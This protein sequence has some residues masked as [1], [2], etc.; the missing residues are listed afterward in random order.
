MKKNWLSTTAKW[1]LVKTLLTE[2]KNNLLG[3]VNAYGS[4]MSL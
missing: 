1:N 4:Y 2:K 3:Q